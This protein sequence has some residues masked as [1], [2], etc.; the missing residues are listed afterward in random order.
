MTQQ[1]AM[2][3][4]VPALSPSDHL[5]LRSLFPGGCLS[6]D[7]IAA[8]L[9]EVPEEA[10][11]ARFQACK[12]Q[13]KMFD[14]RPVE[15]LGENHQRL[16]EKSLQNVLK[17]QET[18]DISGYAENSQID[19][20]A[21]EDALNRLSLL[22]N[23]QP[24]PKL[25]LETSPNAEKAL[26][27]LR[28]EIENQRPI[29]RLV[30]GDMGE[31]KSTFAAALE[32]HCHA[33]TV[34]FERSVIPRGTHFDVFSM[35][36]GIIIPPK[37]MAG[38]LHQ[39]ALAALI[40]PES[41]LI[42]DCRAAF[43]VQPLASFMQDVI[44]H[45]ITH[46]N[47][48]ADSV[49]AQ[50]LATKTVAAISSWYA[51]PSNSRLKAI[52]EFHQRIG[53]S[54]R[55]TGSPS[56][57]EV[58]A[59]LKD[60]LTFYRAAQ[61]H[62][63]WLYDEFE[64]ISQLQANQLDIALGFFRDAIDL[65]NETKGG[66]ILLFS[67][68]DGQRA[69]RQ[70]GALDD[71]LKAADTWSLTAPTWHVQQFSAW[72]AD[73]FLAA[74][75]SLYTRASQIDPMFAG[76]VADNAPLIMELADHAG[77]RETLSDTTLLPRERIKAVIS[78]LD[79][80]V[81][82]ENALR[83]RF[84]AIWPQAYARDEEK[85][86]A[87]TGDELSSDEID[88]LAGNPAPLEATPQTA[89]N[90]IGLN[91][92]ESDIDEVMIGAEEAVQFELG[93]VGQEA[94]GLLD[95]D[96]LNDPLDE[97]DFALP[98]P[99]LC[100]E[101]ALE[102]ADTSDITYKAKRPITSVDE[103]DLA[104]GGPGDGLTDIGRQR[105]QER[106]VED[107]ALCG[108]VTDMDPLA[109]RTPG[110]PLAR[111]LFATSS[112]PHIGAR[113]AAYRDAGGATEGMA[114]ALRDE[115]IPLSLT[116][117][118]EQ[119]SQDNKRLSKLADDV[120][121]L[122]DDQPTITVMTV[123]GPH[124]SVSKKALADEDEMAIREGRDMFGREAFLDAVPYKARFPQCHEAMRLNIAQ[125]IQVLRKFVYTYAATD[126]VMPPDEWVD[127]FVL[128]AAL[129]FFSHQPPT[130]RNGV[131]FI[132]ARGGLLGMF[133]KRRTYAVLPLEQPLTLNPEP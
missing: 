31:G 90:N 65:I 19:F 25:L 4:D 132:H 106:D 54:F 105:Q 6:F 91:A 116:F 104:L 88:D 43:T 131:Q 24:D 122:L 74:L 39:I 124:V 29:I 61:V 98:P 20:M 80:A 11:D 60:F 72:N 1:T 47:S 46:A 76:A 119:K 95:D 130:S 53:E 77:F 85:D 128:N 34:C 50:R 44:T 3:A 23:G 112:V 126:G 101:P 42:K 10:K 22:R 71:R 114:K 51:T 48:Y 7:A 94:S 68:S 36:R 86:Q 118:E 117:L 63:V 45:T 87:L 133:D 83:Q 57:A 125:N 67:T 27:Y 66:S 8:Y 89:S 62:P 56:K 100:D 79:S 58:V 41:P 78:L 35:A 81:N 84:S 120:K 82:G 12:N 75:L 113:V 108:W 69:I 127:R 38:A 103:L 99:F 17:L 37:V 107:T 2:T 64:S 97:E 92:D 121:R 21:A 70:Y 40:D 14:G 102:A 13:I 129:E 73:K 59:V 55:F 109:K 15:Q 30:I 111:F 93:R 5:A 28:Q 115:G 110:K 96:A 16:L 49:N 32:H 26:D 18:P 52:Q 123:S 33:S 9:D